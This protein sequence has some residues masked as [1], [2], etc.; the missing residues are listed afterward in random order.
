M[1]GH[2]E[3]WEECVRLLPGEEFFTETDAML[4]PEAKE[5]LWKQLHR[6]KGN[7]AHFGFDR[8][9][10]M[11]AELCMLLRKEKAG[12]LAIQERYQDLKTEYLRIVERIRVT[13]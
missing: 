13:R 9:A 7:L 8:T 5:A 1:A 10:A 2:M 12:F 4:C 6:L 3:L 11:A